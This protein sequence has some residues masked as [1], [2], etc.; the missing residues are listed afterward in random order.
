PSEDGDPAWRQKQK[1]L[2]QGAHRGGTAA[3]VE[4]L[5]GGARSPQRQGPVVQG[6]GLL[7]SSHFV[8]R[9][10]SLNRLLRTRTVGDGGP[11]ERNLRL[12]D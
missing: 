6:P 7:G 9:A 8:E 11:G 2:A 10:K 1:L 3:S 5:A 12:R 4:C